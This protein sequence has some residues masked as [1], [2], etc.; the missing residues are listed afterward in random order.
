M[1]KRITVACMALLLLLAALLLPGGRPAPRS[2]EHQHRTWPGESAQ[3]TGLAADGTLTSH[4]PLLILHTDGRPI[5]GQDRTDERQL[6]CTYSLICNPSGVNCS[7]DSPALTGQLAVTVRGNSSRDFPKKQYLL[8]LRDEAGLPRK[9]SLLGMPAGSSWV[10]NGSFLDHSTIRNY[11]C[12]NLSA[13][14]MAGYNPQNRFCEVLTTD[15]AGNT[16]YEGLYNLIEKVK[17]APERLDLHPSDPRYA[18]TSFLMQLNAYPDHTRLN[19]LKPDGMPAYPIDLEYPNEPDA[20]AEQLRYVEQQV[21]YFEKALYDASFTGNWEK[22][23]ELTDLDS[24]VDYYLINEFLQNYDA[25]NRSTYLYQDLGRKMAIGPVWDFDGAF[26]NYAG[27]S[28]EIDELRLHDSLLYAFL[29]QDPQFGLRCTARYRELRQ[30][31]LS[32]QY[33]L[34]YIE[35]TAA[36][37]GQAPLRN[38]D[39]WYGGEH[40]LYYQDLAAMKQF[41]VERGAWMDKHFGNIHLISTAKGQ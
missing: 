19:H 36:Y 9:Q 20:T 14:I 40:D 3:T 32:E 5:P 17:V 21:L 29:M 2:I 34:S 28:L 6:L 23:E 39:R 31:F 7:A 8:R 35:D 38:C 16:R 10:L 11:L 18:Q 33:L 30:S 26:N 1:S 15:A 22:V 25:G 27:I 12:Y 24:F 4:L 13:E 41:V 37:L